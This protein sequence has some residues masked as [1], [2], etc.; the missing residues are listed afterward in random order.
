V[1]YPAAIPWWYWLNW[2]M[3]QVIM[4]ARL[5]AMYQGSRMI[6]V[7]LVII[8]LV[9]NIACVVITL[10]GLDYVVGGKLYFL[11][12]RTQLIGQTRG[13][14]NLWHIHVQLWRGGGCPAFCLNDLDAQHRLGG[15]RTVSCSLDCCETLPW[16]ATTWPIDR[17][18]H[19]GLFHGADNISRALLCKVSL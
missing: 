6:L 13:G 12:S 16:P 2:N 8:F 11:T 10:I 15:S 7:F 19:W 18:D 4:I 1:S 9:V 5:H 14:D 17:I 3:I